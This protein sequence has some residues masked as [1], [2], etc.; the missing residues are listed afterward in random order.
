MQDTLYE[1]LQGSGFSLS[2]GA[3][4]TVPHL[5]PSFLQKLA[6]HFWQGPTVEY[7]ACPVVAEPIGNWGVLAGHA[8]TLAYYGFDAEEGQNQMPRF[9]E[10]ILQAVGSPIRAFHLHKDFSGKGQD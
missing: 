6:S 1:R 9:K 5:Q 2:G 4:V 8:L 10:A 7:D 3:E